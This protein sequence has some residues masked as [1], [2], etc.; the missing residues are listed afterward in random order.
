MK[1]FRLGLFEKGMKG[2]MIFGTFFA[3][4]PVTTLP[5]RW[6]RHGTMELKEIPF[7]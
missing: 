5:V 2:W 6:E 3:T 4:G 7:W 1:E